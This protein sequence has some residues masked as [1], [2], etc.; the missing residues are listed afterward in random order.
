MLVL[1]DLGL[2][3]ILKREEHPAVLTENDFAEALFSILFAPSCPV[4][5]DPTGEME[6]YIK[7]KFLSNLGVEK[8]SGADI[9]GNEKLENCLLQNRAAIIK[10]VSMLRKINNGLS[11]DLQLFK[12]LSGTIYNGYDFNDVRTSQLKKINAITPFFSFYSSQNKR[13]QAF[14]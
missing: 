9:F 10:D 8:I 4:I 14:G 7:E 6:K 13:I 11:L 5:G 3:E 1:K 2:K 12:R